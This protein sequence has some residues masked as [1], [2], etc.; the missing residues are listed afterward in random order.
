LEDLGMDGKIVTGL[1]EVGYEGK[2]WI[3]VLQH[4]DI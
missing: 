4:R 2:D 3:H 1:K